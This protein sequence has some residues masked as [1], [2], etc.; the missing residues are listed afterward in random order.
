MDGLGNRFPPEIRAK[1]PHMMP[2]DVIIWERFIR[3]GQFLPDDVW[4]DVKVG[5]GLPVPSGQ[6][7]WMKRMVEYN[8][9]KRIDM[10]WRVGLDYW[11][12]EAKP[13]AGIVA[14]G[15]V[16]FYSEAFADR[17][18]PNYP[19]KR[20]VITDVIDADVK[21]VFDLYSVIV[22]EVG[23]ENSPVFS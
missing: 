18:R 15:Q 9:K 5:I 6:P 19:V 8:Y 17:F 2:E 1:Y 21:P 22:F 3:N 11:V 4:F 16:I 23:F 20:A 12:V 13:F 14:L 7:D 10:V